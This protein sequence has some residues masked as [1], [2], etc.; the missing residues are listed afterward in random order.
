MAD[1]PGKS[2]EWLEDHFDFMF[3]LGKHVRPPEET[4]MPL[5]GGH[6]YKTAAAEIALA[7]LR[8]AHGCDGTMN[9][10]FNA[11]TRPPPPAQV[12]KLQRQIAKL[13]NVLLRTSKLDGIELPEES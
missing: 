8:Q 10:Y 7:A 11:Y 9:Y 1:H 4:T 5:I 13:H 6:T 3:G 12:K 2:E